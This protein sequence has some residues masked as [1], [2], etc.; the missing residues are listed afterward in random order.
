[1]EL[2]AFVKAFLWTFP[3]LTTKYII[4]VLTIFSKQNKNIVNVMCTN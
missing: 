3:V 1:M 2:K 4:H